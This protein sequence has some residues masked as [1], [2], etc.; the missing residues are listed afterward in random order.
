MTVEAPES[1]LETRKWITLSYPTGL[2]K[3][4]LI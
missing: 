4:W 1:L 2:A 3:T